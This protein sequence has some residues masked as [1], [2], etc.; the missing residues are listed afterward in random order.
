M[1]THRSLAHASQDRQAIAPQL[2]FARFECVGRSS[3]DVLQIC[4]EAFAA[5][6]RRRGLRY[7]VSVPASRALHLY[8]RRR[9]SRR[10]IALLFEAMR[11]HNSADRLH[12]PQARTA[13]H[14]RR[15]GCLLFGLAPSPQDFDI[16]VEKFANAARTRNASTAR[17]LRMAHSFPEYLAWNL[18]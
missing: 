8:R 12:R 17:T 4:P 15:M 9:K 1:P 6:Y 2:L 16:A 11:H 5:R 14:C 18:N 10:P 3:L 13:I 7:V